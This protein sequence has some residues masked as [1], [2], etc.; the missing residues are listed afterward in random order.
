M[1]RYRHTFWNGMI[2]V[3]NGEYVK[4]DE[5]LSKIY[6][7]LDKSKVL[8]IALKD[9]E[10]IY[11]ELHNKYFNKK[12]LLLSLTSGLILSVSFNIYYLVI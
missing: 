5:A 6:Y 9:Q 7:W 1:K 8:E 4:K 3:P 12:L 11:K 10:K 2:E